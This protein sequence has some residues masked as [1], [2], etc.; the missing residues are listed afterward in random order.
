LKYWGVHAGLTYAGIAAQGQPDI[1]ALSSFIQDA[2]CSDTGASSGTH[3]SSP[4]SAEGNDIYGEVITMRAATDIRFNRRDSLILQGSAVSWARVHKDPTVTIPHIAELDKVLSYQGS[5][6]LD[7]SYTAS[8]AWQFAWKN[9]HLRLGW[10][11]SV[12]PYAFLTQAAEL[13]IRFGGHARGEQAR[14]YKTWQRNREAVQGSQDA[15]NPTREAE[16]Q[17]ENP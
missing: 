5:V 6:P 2:E 8:I 16:P 1:C 12:I 4:L 10:G 7:E 3:A 9:A 17:K 13:S 14:R 15:D 11:V